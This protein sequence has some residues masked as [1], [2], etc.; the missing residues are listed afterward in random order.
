MGGGRGR[1]SP[2]SSGERKAASRVAAVECVGRGWSKAG[3]IHPPARCAASLPPVF[4]PTY[5]RLLPELEK[6][7]LPKET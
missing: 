4:T 5:Q 7:A 2:R 3:G 1:L 6:E